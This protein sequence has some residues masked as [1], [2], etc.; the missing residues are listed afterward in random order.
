MNINTQTTLSL[1]N[2]FL[3]NPEITFL[4]FGSFGACPKTV[5]ADYQNWQMQ[6]ERNPVQFIKVTG[7]QYLKQ[8][9]EALATYLQCNP[10]DVVF[11]TNPS[12][13]VNII[14][15]GLQLQPGDE[16][17]TTDLEY[18]ACDK[19]WN[20]YC[21]KS[22]AVYKQH[23]ITLP[24][25]SKENFVEQFFAGVTSRTKLIFLSH[26]TSTTALRFP[27]EQICKR[28]KELGILTF[29]DGAHAPGHVPIDLSSMQADIYTGAC[30]KWMMTPKGCSFLYV[31][32]ELQEAFAPLII[33]WGYESAIPG[34]STFLD[35]HQ[36]QGTRDFSAFLTV[37]KA[38]QFMQAHD[39]H[40]VSQNCRTLVLLNAQRFCDLL[41]VQS[42]CPITDDFLVQ[43]FSIPIKTPDVSALN[44]LLLQKYKIEIPVMPH[45]DKV[46]LRFSV[47]V[48]NTQ[49][50]LD[51]LYAALQDIAATTNLLG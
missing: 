45:A 1:Q 23:P 29:I 16:I 26:I 24:L 30:H 17:L 49:K 31:K 42:I 32:P 28:A 4:N 20:F 38:I 39:W 25:S 6:L 11:V 14:A 3:L 37:P 21:K 8:S 19:T 41:Q 10:Q 44:Q 40:L 34:E 51:I 18:G 43:M 12:Y 48:F 5:F 13:A 33:S 27:V 46:Y 9:R 2:E 36:L 15:K 35:W 22:G 47:Q 7:F 50:D